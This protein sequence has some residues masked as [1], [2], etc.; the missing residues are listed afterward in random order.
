MIYKLR[1]T[2]AADYGFLLDELNNKFSWLKQHGYLL[3]I[4]SQIIDRDPNIH[5]DLM[6]H[7]NTIAAH[8]KDEDIVYIFKHQISEFLA[9]HIVRDW[10]DKLAWKEVNRKGRHIPPGD[11]MTIFN[12]AIEFLKR[13][14]SNESLNL[15]MNYGRKNKIAHKVLDYIYYH[16]Y[17]VMDGF[18]KFCMKDYLIEI[19]FAVDLAYEELKNEKEY[20]EFVKLL[21]YFVDTQP[22]TIQEVNIMMDKQ[23]RFF[24]WDGN[25]IR[26]E[27]N[28]VNYYLDDIARG[29]ISLDDMLVSILI[30][31]AP[32]RIILHNT[33]PEPRSESVKMI[34]KVFEKRITECSGCEQC[35]EHQKNEERTTKLEK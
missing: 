23:G 17:L 7:G 11:Q 2:T 25:G 9:E 15:L 4:Q 32:R 18:I 5:F 30:T 19:K 27:Q 16:D 24:L 1:I 28:H 12:K 35:Y 3:S 20:N 34:K 10:E 29:E 22:P 33:G 31:I 6:L 21:R 13:C 14:N 8:L 26:L